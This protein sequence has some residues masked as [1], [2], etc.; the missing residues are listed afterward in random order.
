[1]RF[2]YTQGIDEL[3]MMGRGL[4]AN[5]NLRSWSYNRHF[6][7]QAILAPKFTK[8][9]IDWM[10]ELFN[11]MESYWNKLYLNEEKIKDDQNKL[12]CSAWLNRYTNDMIIALTT[13]ERSYKMASYFN[14]QSDERAVHPQSHYVPFFKSKSDALLRNIEFIYQKL[15]LIIQRRRQEIEN[16]SLEKPLSHDML[17]SL[18][19]ANTFGTLI[20]LKLSRTAN[21]LSFIIYHIASNPDV[22][23]KM[24]EEIDIVFQGDKTRSITEDDYEKLKY[25][26]AIIK[27]V[28]RI[29]PVVNTVARFS[30]EPDEIAGYKWPAG[31]LFHVNTASIHKN[32]NYW[33][34]PEKFNPDRWMVKDFKPKK[35]SFVMFGGG[36]RICPGRKLAMIEMICLMALLYRKYDIDL[37]DKLSPLKTISSGLIASPE[38]VE[39]FTPLGR[40]GHS[41]ILDENK[42]YFFGGQSN[43]DCSNEVFYL[44]LSQRFNVENLQW[45][46][47]TL[48]SEIAFKN[49]YVSFKSLVYVF[50][51]KSGQWNIPVMKGNIPEM[52]R[53]F[54]V[55]TDIFGN[56][57]V[58]GG[59]SDERMGSIIVQYYKNMSISNTNDLTWSY[60]PDINIPLPRAG[61]TAS[62]L[63]NGVITRDAPTGE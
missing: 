59:L 50:N 32:K 12:D 18:I 44:D 1:M 45:T 56:I 39:P 21:L 47:L 25:C 23:R 46:D 26:E 29:L 8:K 20:M 2:P 53:D 57:Y 60:G 28:D 7:T 49:N 61:N 52:R 3:G 43:I 40:M 37:V 36:L 15:E 63:S 33:E 38:L 51:L 48:N 4:L 5:H 42:L 34:E 19:A 54:N 14:T 41:T 30:Q 62:L 17:T 9:T 11:E 16:T 55:V 10:N 13:G 6:F 24:F 31:T 22:K 35:F 27:E 58:S